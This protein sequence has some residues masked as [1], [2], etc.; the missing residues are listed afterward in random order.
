VDQ[1]LAGLPEDLRP[2]RDQDGN[3]ETILAVALVSLSMTPSLSFKDPLILEMKQRVYAIGAFDVDIAPSAAVPSAGPSFGHKL[4]S[5]ERKAAV[6]PATGNYLYFGTIDKQTGHLQGLRPAGRTKKKDPETGSR[7]DRTD[8][9]SSSR[10]NVHIFAQAAAILKFHDAGNFGKQSIITADAHIQT[11]FDLGS[12]LPHEDSAA[13]DQLSGK[14][15]YAK[16]LRLAVSA[17]PGASHSLFVCHTL[18]L[19]LQH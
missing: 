17:I 1:L 3:I 8:N 19:N 10:L 14:P 4:F 11:R 6:P 2:G 15:F 5:P 13:V 9:Q 18:P 12:P 7:R 16:P